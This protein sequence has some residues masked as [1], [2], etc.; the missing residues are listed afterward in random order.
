MNTVIITGHLTHD[1]VLEQLPNG[2]AICGV[3]V[4]HIERIHLKGKPSIQKTHLF[5]CDLLGEGASSFAQ[6]HKKGS[7]VLFNGKLSSPSE[8][9]GGDGSTRVVVKYWERVD[10]KNTPQYSGEDEEY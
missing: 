10:F 4:A 1:P 6:Y 7:F 3:T 8:R 9:S 5:D 2:I